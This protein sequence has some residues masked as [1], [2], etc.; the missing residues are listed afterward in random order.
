[1][2]TLYRFPWGNNPKRIELRGRLFRVLAVGKLNSAL[3]EF[4]DTGQREIISRNALCR[5][6]N[7]KKH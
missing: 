6:S 4:L 7:D 5:K 3:V 1:M 2:K